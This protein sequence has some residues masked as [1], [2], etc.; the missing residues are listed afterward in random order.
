MLS[1]TY[2]VKLPDYSLSYLINGDSTGLTDD[3]KAAIDRYMDDYYNTALL[4][5]GDVVIELESQEGY[6]TWYPPFGLACNVYDCVI[7]ILYDC[8]EG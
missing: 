3:D 8:Q 5:H 7:A 1:L 4:Y 2:E 6:F